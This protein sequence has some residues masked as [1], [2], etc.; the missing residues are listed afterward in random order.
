[1]NL[2]AII[3]ISLA[4]PL[5]APAGEAGQDALRIQAAC[6]DAA[7]LEGDIQ[8]CTDNT[9]A[10]QHA[11]ACRDA[12]LGAW[13]KANAELTGVMAAARQ[14][15]DAKQQQDFFRSHADMELAIDKMQKLVD[16]TEAGADR[17]AQYARVMFDN[18]YADPGL[19]GSSN[20]Y[21]S[22]FL[23]ISKIVDDL[24]QKA[25]QGLDAIASVDE[26]RG[27]SQA[28]DDGLGTTAT[29][30]A[31][32]TVGAG[33]GESVNGKSDVTGIAQDKAK[34]AGVPA[35]GVTNTVS[36][37]SFRAPA[38]VAVAA[39]AAAP[40]PALANQFEPQIEKR[41]PPAGRSAPATGASRSVADGLFAGGTPDDHGVLRLVVPLAPVN[42]P[43]SAP[44][45][46]GAPAGAPTGTAAST[47][48]DAPVD[49]QI[50]FYQGVSEDSP[51]PSPKQ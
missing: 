32:G 49:T 30:M 6:A 38:S 23:A 51:A 2:L 15:L 46:T 28:R 26:L 50:L 5:A 27:V 11:L 14:K 22:H 47:D 29:Q 10:E 31:K 33:T 42:A 3:A 40:T 18:P 1:M 20:C 17:L 36:R 34:Q 24:D 39:P 44:S 8:S 21:K 45:L 25:R 35:A 7:D 9:V 16:D 13:E 43:A 37:P 4:L 41:S 12:L 19:V 48:P